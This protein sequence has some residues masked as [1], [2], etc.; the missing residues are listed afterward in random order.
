M[1]F[2]L[3]K[4]TQLEHAWFTQK[5]EAMSF[6]TEK[7]KK[8]LRRKSVSWNRQSRRLCI[9]RNS[10]HTVTIRH[11]ESWHWSVNTPKVWRKK[12]KWL[13]VRLNHTL[14]YPKYDIS[15]LKNVMIFVLSYF[16]GIYLTYFRK[17]YDKFSHFYGLN[18]WQRNLCATKSYIGIIQVF[19]TGDQV[20]K[21]SLWV[22]NNLSILFESKKLERETFLWWKWS[23]KSTPAWVGDQ[24]WEFQYFKNGFH[25]NQICD[26][27]AF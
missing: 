16:F 15:D 18:S 24:K 25:L 7:E 1:K 3:F 26:E 22:K 11:G 5:F 20:S 17:E 8:R 14:L 4:G 2:Q 6:N 12:Y 23:R 13:F 10:T 19:V 9:P 27:V 21:I